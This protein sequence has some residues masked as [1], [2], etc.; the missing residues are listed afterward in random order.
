MGAQLGRVE[1]SSTGRPAPGGVAQGVTP[2]NHWA[3]SLRA[4]DT[5][6][7]TGMTGLNMSGTV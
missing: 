5:T 3:V 4:L 1:A 6:G 2:A 7:G